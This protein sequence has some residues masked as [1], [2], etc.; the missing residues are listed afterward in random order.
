MERIRVAVVG[1]GPAGLQAS[2]ALAEKGYSPLVFE[3]HPVI[4]QPIQCGEGISYN[5]LKEFSLLQERN[6]FCVREY[7]DCKL[8]IPHENLIMGD[9]HSFTI[10]RDAFDQCLER[11]AIDSGAIIKTSTKV[12]DVQ[13]KS[14]GYLL[15]TSGE[16][17]KEYLCDILILA[18]GPNGYLARNLGFNVPSPLIKAFEYKIK[19]EWGETLEFYFN[20]EKYPYGYCWIFPKEDQTNVGIVTT[21][22]ERK[23]RLDN[24]LKEKGITDNVLKKIGGS[25]PMNGPLTKIYDKNVLLAGDTAGMVNPIFYGGI[26]LAMISGRSAGRVATKNLK[27]M[28]LGDDLDF[29]EYKDDLKKYPFMKK[30]NLKCHNYF[31]GSSNDFLNKIGQVFDGKYINRI[32]RRQVGDIIWKIVK[33]PTLYTKLRILYNL[34]VGFLIARDWGF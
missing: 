6:Q 12:T 10:N 24:F 26:R 28:E 9:I 7:E 34:Y 3:E 20:S 13:K 17:Q 25:I 21:A 32:K 2:T 11:K 30:I 5:A 23:K 31:Y 14:D 8:F 18:E 19:G 29:Q 33:K 22:P 1:A 27:R 4:G 15:R 16:K